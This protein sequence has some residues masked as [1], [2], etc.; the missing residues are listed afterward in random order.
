MEH[1]E[2]S[3]AV[4]LAKSIK[5]YQ[6]RDEVTGVRPLS[7]GMIPSS[8]PAVSSG[9]IT[10]NTAWSQ[11]FHRGPHLFA[12]PEIIRPDLSQLP[13]F[14]ASKPLDQSL[15]EA[16]AQSADAHTEIPWPLT[17]SPTSRPP[18]PGPT[19]VPSPSHSRSQSRNPSLNYLRPGYTEYGIAPP[20][21]EYGLAP[22]SESCNP[23]RLSQ[24]SMPLPPP[25]PPQVTGAPP[26]TDTTGAS[27]QNSLGPRQS[28]LPAVR[29]GL[30]ATTPGSGHTRPASLG[31]SLSGSLKS[32]WSQLFA[33]Q[34]PSASG[35]K[36][37]QSLYEQA[38]GADNNQELDALYDQVEQRQEQEEIREAETA[39]RQ[40]NQSAVRNSQAPRG[41]L[42]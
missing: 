25:P 5:F 24:L 7:S 13:G 8:A 26:L 22:P 10:S 20:T 21:T 19:R 6:F 14:P 11:G 28:I 41:G 16:M 33:E 34:T 1:L 9:V 39:A 3:A 38:F 30:A 42:Y 18:S 37:G 15:R 4:L 23:N 27:L 36:R 40:S 32:V 2:R 35:A 29:A 31:D 12:Q 17:R